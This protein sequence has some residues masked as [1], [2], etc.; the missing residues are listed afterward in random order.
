MSTA[1]Q[2]TA[3]LGDG[4]QHPGVIR[5]HR[6][7]EVLVVFDDPLIYGGTGW[8]WVPEDRVTA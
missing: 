2:V 7:G 1:E 5:R 6:D 3:D 4:I 8:A